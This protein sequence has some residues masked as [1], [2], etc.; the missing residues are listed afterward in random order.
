MLSYRHAFHAGNHADVLKHVVLLQLLEHLAAKDKPFWYIDTHAG[1]GSYTL[2]ATPSASTG[3]HETGV[4]PLW[5]AKGLPTALARYVA[6]LHEM[7]PRGRLVHYPGSPWIARA[8][9]RQH[10]QLW[11]HE[12]HPADHARL[13]RGFAASGCH[14]RNIDGLDALKA[15]LPP[16]PRR[17]LVLIDPSYELREDYMRLPSV[18]QQGLQRFATGIYLVWYPML[19]RRDA[20]E[21][22]ARLASGVPRWL[23]A[24]LAIGSATEHGLYG[25][26]V[27]VVNPPW[28]L[29]A[30]L[31]E[32]LPRLA[33]LLGQD[34]H[35]RYLLQTSPAENDG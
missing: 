6:L 33:A 34:R 11:L 16:Q 21:L 8:R 5:H 19:A 22:P 27:F 17:A 24:E 4:V 1:A 28:T 20:H 26:G 3:E 10:D 30:T 12:L 18:L 31:A 23:R 14:V 13:A 25:S 15:L 29:Q 35:A 2:T 32:V 7:N 9:M